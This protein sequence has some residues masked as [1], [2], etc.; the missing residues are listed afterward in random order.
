[1]AKKKPYLAKTLTDP[2]DL[3][4]LLSAPN[5]NANFACNNQ[6]QQLT[7]LWSNGIQASSEWL[8]LAQWCWGIQWGRQSYFRVSVPLLIT[9]LLKCSGSTCAHW[10]PSSWWRSR[11]PPSL[12]MP[13]NST[14][15]G[16]KDERE[17]GTD[18]HQY[19]HQKRLLDAMINF[20]YTLYIWGLLTLLNLDLLLGWE[21]IFNDLPTMTSVI[22]C[23]LLMITW[24]AI[25]F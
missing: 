24:L 2:I 12:S 6:R 16:V 8:T 3:M 14:A 13:R 10:R 22:P 4:A 11:R 21:S 20:L 15:K 25:T 9:T 19:A 23:V 5:P 18:S 17:I 1:M 7:V